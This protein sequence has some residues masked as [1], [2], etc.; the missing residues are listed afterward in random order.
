MG[1]K[2]VTANAVAH[3]PRARP[4]P[5]AVRSSPHNASTTPSGSWRL[6]HPRGPRFPCDQGR[7][8]RGGGAGRHVEDGPSPRGRA[9]S[10]WQCA[11]KFKPHQF[12]FEQIQLHT[13]IIMVKLSRG[14]A[15][16]VARGAETPL[17]RSPNN[18]RKKCCAPPECRE[19]T[20]DLE[21]WHPVRETPRWHMPHPSHPKRANPRRRARCVCDRSAQL[22]RCPIRPISSS[23][24]ACG[25]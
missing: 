2:L 5:V 13:I 25:A 1:G 12:V 19:R 22:T 23:R 3:D 11:S 21:K 15:A 6:H 4:H 18:V 7:D 16:G 17:S 20:P 9:A 10:Q 24:C 8:R 14:A